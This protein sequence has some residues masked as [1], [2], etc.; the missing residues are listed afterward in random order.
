M[1]KCKH[2]KEQF[3]PYNSLQKYCFKDECR[4]IWIESEKAKQWQK[5][6]AKIKQ[7]LMTIQDYIKIAQQVF[8]KY[9]RLRD[10]GNKCISCGKD[11]KENEVVHASH[12][13]PAGTC[14]ATRFNEDNV[15]VSCVKCNNF[16]SGN[17]SEYRI[18][19]V[20]KIGLERVEEIER[21]SVDT[22]KF[23]IDELKE[24]I[25]EYKK[26]IKEL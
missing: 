14:W 19:L 17:L 13:K 20:N 5:K 22:K 1:K 24:I 16:L 6:K 25:N 4:T 15:H 21:L 3:Q 10:K 7:D 23:T 11:I 26:K 12:Y 8:N 9:I 2:C 18:R